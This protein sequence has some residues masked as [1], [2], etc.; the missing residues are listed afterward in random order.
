MNLEHKLGSDNPLDEILT[1]AGEL[2]SNPSDADELR[3]EL[4]E[5]IE[6][7]D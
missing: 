1:I 2:E 4:I 6:S 7:L 5:K 3:K